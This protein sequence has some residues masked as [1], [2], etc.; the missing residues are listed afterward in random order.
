MKSMGRAKRYEHGKSGEEE[1]VEG[2]WCQVTKERR[3]T[4][5]SWMLARVSGRKDMGERL[6]A[7]Y[8]SH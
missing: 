2:Q 7:K 6:C 3:V 1:G 8:R 4:N 5:V